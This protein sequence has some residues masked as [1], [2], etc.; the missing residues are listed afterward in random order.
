MRENKSHEICF[1]IGGRVLRSRAAKA[2]PKNVQA[3]GII[4]LDQPSLT[5]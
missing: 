2:M 4:P 3:P 1:V 5:C